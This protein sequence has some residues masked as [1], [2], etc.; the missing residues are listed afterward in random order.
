MAACQVIQ[1]HG[2]ADVALSKYRIIYGRKPECAQVWNNIGMCFFSKK[3]FVAAVSCLKRA[4]YLAPFELYVLYN[5]ALVHLYLQQNAS[6]AIFLQSAIRINKK[7]AQSYALLGVALSKLKDADNAL[8]AF[9]YSLKLDPTDP[10]TLLNLAILQVN[11]GVT[12]SKIDATI[13]QFHRYYS[14]RLGS[15]TQQEVDTSMLD[16]ATK[17]EVSNEETAPSSSIFSS[18]QPV[19]EDPAISARH[20]PEELPNLKTKTDYDGRHK[21]R[22][23]IT[24]SDTEQSNMNF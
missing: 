24:S 3:K 4:N 1:K 11:T 9:T 19:D 7:H 8:R 23:A 16:I 17:L 2:D 15:T 21:S 18:R 10:M 20:T 12:Q 5:L 6:A 13:K 14:E 22:R